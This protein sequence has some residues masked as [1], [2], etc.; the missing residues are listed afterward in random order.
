MR[1]EYLLKFHIVKFS[2][3]QGRA[4]VAWPGRV[5]ASLLPLFTPLIS[6]LSRVGRLAPSEMDL[7]EEA[8]HMETFMEQEERLVPATGVAHSFFLDDFLR[9]R[10]C[11]HCHKFLWGLAK[12]GY[13]CSGTPASPKRS[14]GLGLGEATSP[15]PCPCPRPLSSSFPFV[16][17]FLALPCSAHS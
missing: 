14:A 12:Q 17:L 6:P 5:E 1:S 11:A 8:Y 7:Q 10:F 4:G 3:D 2:Q 9:P 15:P 13:R 16:L